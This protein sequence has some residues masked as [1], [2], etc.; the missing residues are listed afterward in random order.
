[1][2]TEFR[3]LRSFTWIA[4]CTALAAL[5]VIA[6]AAQR[7][8]SQVSTMQPTDSSAT[9]L[10]NP[11]TFRA[12][13]WDLEDSEWQR[14]QTL[15]QGVRGSVSP[16]TLSPIEVL[17]I[18][19]RST[20][21]RRR[22]AK[23]WAL[24]MREDAE[25]ILAFQRAYDEAQRRFFPSGLLIDASVVNARKLDQD[26]VKNL[27]WQPTDRVLFFTDTQCSTCDAVLERL[28]SQLEHISGIDLYLIDVTAGE[29][30]QIR[31]WAATKQI[32]PQWINDHKVTLNIDAGARDRVAAHT[33]QQKQALPVVVLRRGDQIT[34]LP[35]WHF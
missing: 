12:A 2:N 20:E 34:P 16:S 28:L 26:L 27:S 18:H 5:P 7:A 13:Q 1:M 11:L 10:I 15:M 14:Y 8:D 24:M 6:V 32:D 30:S 29:E 3:V 35:A 4:G 17:G 22:Y 9:Q 19:A 21:E 25:R 31:E 33:G 23:Q